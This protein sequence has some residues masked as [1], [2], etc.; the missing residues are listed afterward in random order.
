MK[1]EFNV[2]EEMEPDPVLNRITNDIIGA[3]IEVH[4]QLGP[5]L[6]ESIYEN[7]LAIEFAARNVPFMRQMQVGVNYKGHHIG[8]LRLDFVVAER[9]VVEL[10][11][12][13]FLAPIHKAQLLCY[14]RITGH[15]LGILI[16]FNVP[17]L[18]EGIKRIAN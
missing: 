12:V 8:E 10:K 17:V 11:S 5:G 6:P 9:V 13:E 14:L 1:S 3:A 18:K 7:A 4:R 2:D 16:N 15:K